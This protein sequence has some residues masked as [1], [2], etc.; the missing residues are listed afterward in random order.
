MDLQ[1]ANCKTWQNVLIEKG[2]DV[3]TAK[4]LIGFLSWNRDEE[5]SKLGKEITEILSGYKG[6]IFAKDVVSTNFNDKGILF[7]SSD[8]SQE[9]A[10]RIFEA[11]M[12]YEQND[13]YNSIH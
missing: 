1:N 3:A 9:T 8:I 10:N 7:F 13:V 5:F 4:T 6:S 2:F 12:G 11:I